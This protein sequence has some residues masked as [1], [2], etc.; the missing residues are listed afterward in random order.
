MALI[1]TNNARFI[2]SDEENLLDALEHT[3]HEVEYQCRA[4]Y[5]GSCR[6]KIR[7]GAENISYADFPLAF[8]SRDEILPCCC[9]VTGQIEIDCTQEKVPADV[10]PELF[11]DNNT[12]AQ[13]VEQVSAEVMTLKKP[14]KGSQD[15]YPMRRVC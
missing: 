11:P 15:D 12:S 5:C 9:T 14:I 6:T 10:Q 7:Q 2:L 1:T 3:G 13:K 8:V 4:G